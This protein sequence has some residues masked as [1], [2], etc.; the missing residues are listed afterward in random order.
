M[1]GGGEVFAEAGLEGGPKM[2]ERV[3]VGGIGGQE[4]P[5]KAWVRQPFSRWSGRDGSWRCPTRHAAW[6]QRGQQHLGEINLHDRRVATALKGQRRDQLAL[7]ER[8]NEAGAFLAFA[9]HGFVD[10]PP[11]GARPNSRYSR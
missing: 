9:R 4:Q 7:P 10:P 2:F 11:R 8:P 1:G 5:L 6:R 3:E